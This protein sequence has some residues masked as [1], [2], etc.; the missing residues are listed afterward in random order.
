MSIPISRCL[1]CLAALAVLAL[2]N[3]V[4][5]FCP[6][7]DALYFSSCPCEED[8]GESGCPCQSGEGSCHNYLHLDCDDFC[9]SGLA[10][11]EPKPASPDASLP[12]PSPMVSLGTT[13]GADFQRTPCAN[14]PPPFFGVDLL[15]QLC[16]ARI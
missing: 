5:G 2:Q 14:A 1:T 6:H 7:H 8:A 13:Q 16:R 11:A 10:S 3:L 15:R 4:L 12:G 9:W